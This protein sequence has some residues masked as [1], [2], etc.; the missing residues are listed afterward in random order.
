MLVIAKLVSVAPCAITLGPTL[1]LFGSHYSYIRKKGQESWWKHMM[2]FKALAQNWH[3]NTAHI[4]LAQASHQ[5]TAYNGAGN[6]TLSL[7]GTKSHMAMG[8][9]V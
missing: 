5:T 9:A 8:A 1:G 7:R 4:P 6:G 3:A 2:T